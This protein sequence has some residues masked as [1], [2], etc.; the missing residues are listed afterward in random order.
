[1]RN[2][3]GMEIF[4]FENSAT[5]LVLGDTL[6][7]VRAADILDVAPAMLVASVVPSLGSHLLNPSTSVYKIENGKNHL[8]LLT[9]CNTI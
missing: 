1:M 7:A 5:N 4:R 2:W 6:G 9:T 3:A 8:S